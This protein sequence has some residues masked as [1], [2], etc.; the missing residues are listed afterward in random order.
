[1]AERPTFV[2]GEVPR[3]TFAGSAVATRLRLATGAVVIALLAVLAVSVDT[4]PVPETTRWER[5]MDA[6]ERCR[7]FEAGTPEEIQCR[8]EAA[9][10]P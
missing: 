9:A 5:V 2:F 3:V 10:L 1:V 6:T 8:L 7:V 4:P